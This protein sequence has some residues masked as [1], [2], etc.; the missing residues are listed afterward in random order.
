MVSLKDNSS[1]YCCLYEHNFKLQ[2]IA[3][4]ILQVDWMQAVKD[5]IL[6][7]CADTFILVFSSI[8]SILTPTF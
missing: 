2:A 6:P 8:I 4:V 3:H 1:K 7:V 5:Y